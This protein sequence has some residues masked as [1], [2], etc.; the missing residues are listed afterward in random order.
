MNQSGTFHQFKGV[1]YDFRPM[2]GSL[3]LD[4]ATLLKPKKI[5]GGCRSVF[6]A[7]FCFW[8]LKTFSSTVTQFTD[9]LTAVKAI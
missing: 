5:K 9:F 1:P 7:C 2:C 3:F 4:L 6:A 8:T